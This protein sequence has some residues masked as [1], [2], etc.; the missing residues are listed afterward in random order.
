MGCPQENG[1]STIQSA[2]T[3]SVTICNIIIVNAKE[4]TNQNV[5]EF[6]L[7]VRRLLS[8]RGG[9]QERDMFTA[10]RP[11]LHCRITGAVASIT[12]DILGK[13][14]EENEYQIIMCHVTWVVRIYCLHGS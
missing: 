14:W 10:N 6:T 11:E 4:R 13:V 1:L 7:G 8:A 5:N 2:K 3:N 9:V 12:L